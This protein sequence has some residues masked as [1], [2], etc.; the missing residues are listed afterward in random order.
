MDKIIVKRNKIGT[1]I[2]VGLLLVAELNMIIMMLLA[3]SILGWIFGI[4]CMIM[5]GFILYLFYNNLFQMVEISGNEIRIRYS[6]RIVT[7]MV[8]ECSFEH[9][10]RFYGNKK[11]DIIN[12]THDKYHFI[13]I[14]SLR[15]KNYDEL[16]EYI[17]KNNI[18]VNAENTEEFN[19]IKKRIL[20][21]TDR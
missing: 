8:E 3:K 11:A 15:Y 5:T 7:N 2:A 10:G 13:I 19:K 6:R 16:L 20:N 17:V 1:A 12:L 21:Y 9:N 4:F 14:D 18:K